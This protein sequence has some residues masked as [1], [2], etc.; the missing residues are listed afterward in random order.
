MREVVRLMFLKNLVRD[1]FMVAVIAK[2]GI[3]NSDYGVIESDIK[4]VFKKA[5]ILNT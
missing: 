5:G 1:D 2:P 4:K 3:V